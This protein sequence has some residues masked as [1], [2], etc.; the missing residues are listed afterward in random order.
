M[1]ILISRRENIFASLCN[2]QIVQKLFIKNMALIG[3]AK[4]EIKV[5]KIVIKD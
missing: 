3:T 5:E 1:C 2:T 4:M